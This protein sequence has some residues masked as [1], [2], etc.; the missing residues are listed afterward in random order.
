MNQ[1]DNSSFLSRSCRDY[2]V[3]FVD[4]VGAFKNNRCG[5]SAVDHHPLN[6]C[7]KPLVRFS[8]SKVTARLSYVTLSEWEPLIGDASC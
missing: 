5:S 3:C 1:T 8:K 2:S 6:S 7:C 4:G